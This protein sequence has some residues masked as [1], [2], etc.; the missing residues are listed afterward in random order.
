MLEGWDRGHWDKQG[1]AQRQDQ[2]HKETPPGHRALRL[3]GENRLREGTLAGCGSQTEADGEADRQERPGQGQTDRDERGPEGAGELET[4]LC[5]GQAGCISYEGDE[6]QAEQI[7]RDWKRD[8]DR[9]RGDSALG[10]RSRGQCREE[11]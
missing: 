9:P 10:T 6:T 4:Q 7:K 5:W 2:Q 8:R 3:Q 1:P 11:V